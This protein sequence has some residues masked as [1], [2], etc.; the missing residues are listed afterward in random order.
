MPSFA[1]GFDAMFS[2]IEENLQYP[3]DA[4]KKSVGGRVIV[5][6]IVEKDGSLSNAHIAKS[7]HP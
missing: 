6:F 5:T 2:W 7:V 1:G 3:Q 4:Y